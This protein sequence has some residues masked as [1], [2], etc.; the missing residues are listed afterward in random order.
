MSLARLCYLSFIR[1]CIS[2][3]VKMTNVYVD[4]FTYFYIVVRDCV[5]YESRAY[6]A[7]TR[8]RAYNM[9]RRNCNSNMIPRDCDVYICCIARGMFSSIVESECEFYL[10]RENEKIHITRY[11]ESLV[12]DRAIFDDTRHLLVNVYTLFYSVYNVLSDIKTYDDKAKFC[13][14]QLR[15]RNVDIVKYV[16]LLCK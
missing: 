8:V 6:A 14:V 2:E 5:I 9:L 15:K 11:L 13:F 4:K 7:R 3:S 16:N 10:M 12:D 1:Y